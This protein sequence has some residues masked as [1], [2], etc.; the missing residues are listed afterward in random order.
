MIT[1]AQ[2]R[3][4]RAALGWGVRELAKRAGLS[5]NTVSRFE[6]GSGAMVDTLNQIQLALEKGGIVFISPD[7]G[8]GPGVRFKKKP[9]AEKQNQRSN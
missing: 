1:P 2:V 7:A 8:G 5:P 9:R 4:A 3:M 6:N